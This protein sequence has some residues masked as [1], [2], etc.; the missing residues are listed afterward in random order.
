VA[1]RDGTGALE[2][3]F[4]QMIKEGI[5]VRDWFRSYCLKWSEIQRFELEPK[6]DWRGKQKLGVCRTP[7][8]LADP[9]QELLGTRV[10]RCAE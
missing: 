4:R 9:S 3:L 2:S 7:G 10:D 5:K 6:F 8:R 1:Q